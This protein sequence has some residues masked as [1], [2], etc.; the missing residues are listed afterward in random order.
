MSPGGASAAAWAAFDEALAG[1]L[2]GSGDHA[3]SVAIAV[4][5]EIVHRAAFGYRVP[6]PPAPPVDPAATTIEPT[7]APPSTIVAD[8]PEEI[9]PGDRFR[10]A[11]ISKVITATVVLQLV[12][13]GQI[14]LDGPVGEVLAARSERPSATRPSPGSRS[15]S[16]SRTHRASAPTS[17]RSSGAGGLV[18]GRRPA[19]V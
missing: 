18:P 12:E 1:R 11:S 6:P 4:H 7:T 2:I 14:Q 5:G 17:G 15:A 13:A 9:E 10:I 16:C 3:A 8:A 19:S